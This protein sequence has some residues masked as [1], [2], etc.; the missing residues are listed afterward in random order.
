[1]HLCR[2]SWW[3]V[4]HSCRAAPGCG[5]D[6]IAAEDSHNPQH[7]AGEAPSHAAGLWPATICGHAAAATQC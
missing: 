2:G 5:Q 3:R 7:D 6:S 1:M 4:W